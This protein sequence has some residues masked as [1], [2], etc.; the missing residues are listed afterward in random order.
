VASS[1]TA[2]ITASAP[3]QRT[4]AGDGIDRQH[5]PR[6][7][8][9]SSAYG[10]EPDRTETQHG[11]GAASRDIRPLGPDPAGVE[12]VREQQGRFVAHAIGNAQELEVGGGDGDHRC[13]PTA[14][15]A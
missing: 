3:L 12:I 1:A 13:L 7:Q 2:S 4:P 6:A 5:P 15:H 11:H 14:E 10:A 8:L 9:E